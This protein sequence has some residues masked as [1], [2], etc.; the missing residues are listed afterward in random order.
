MTFYFADNGGGRNWKVRSASETAA[1]KRLAKSIG[2]TVAASKRA[3]DIVLPD[4]SVAHMFEDLAEHEKAVG[5][6]TTSRPVPGTRKRRAY[7]PE[8]RVWKGI[9]HRKGTCGHGGTRTRDLR[10]AVARRDKQ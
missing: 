6:L 10:D 5:L 3:Y 4:R 7:N 2:E 1:W 9:S 8:R